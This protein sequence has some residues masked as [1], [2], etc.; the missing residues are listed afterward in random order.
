MKFSVSLFRF[1]GGLPLPLEA[2]GKLI[3][4]KLAWRNELA[5]SSR[6]VG[7]GAVQVLSG[8]VDGDVMA[9]SGIDGGDAVAVSWPGGG[10]ARKSKRRT[11]S[12]KLSKY[13]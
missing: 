3:P 4:P 13:P 11:S 1:V 7:D 12:N 5:L 9:L 8:G 10:G 6:G 2:L